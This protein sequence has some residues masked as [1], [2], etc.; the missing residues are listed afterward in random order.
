MQA[1]LADAPKI[2]DALCDEC[3]EHFTRVRAY[4]DACAVRYELAPT[5][6]RGL[7]YYTRTTFEFKD[8]TIGAQDTICGG[9]R[10]DGLIEEIGGPPTPG[11]GFGAGIE[12][13]LL[14]ARH[15]QGAAAAARGR[16][17]RLRGVGR[18]R[19]DPPAARRVAPARAASR[20]RL[21]RTLAERATA[22]M[23]DR[24]GAGWIVIVDDGR[25]TV[26]EAGRA[27]WTA[28][29]DEVVDRISG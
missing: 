17:L 11:I 1:L 25:A 6:V 2:G 5:L 26:R 9:G 15:D 8:D 12:R 29:L 7:D 13:L 10:Y 4:L 18:P 3:R 24:L 14:S 28:S 16:V 20:R 19:Q 21:R 27:D 22:R 23:P